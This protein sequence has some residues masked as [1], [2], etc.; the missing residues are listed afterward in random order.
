MSVE[1]PKL[2]SLEIFQQFLTF[3]FQIKAVGLSQNHFLSCFLCSFPRKRK[4]QQVAPKPPW[5]NRS[6]S[7]EKREKKSLTSTGDVLEASVVELGRALSLFPWKAQQLGG[8]GPGHVAVELQDQ[9]DVAA[10]NLRALLTAPEGTCALAAMAP[11]FVT[12]FLGDA[13]RPLG[14]VQEKLHNVSVMLF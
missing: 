10:G 13:L 14:S 8:P 7:N 3:L 9:V 12:A 2:H 6:I 4:F 5:Q 11:G 1:M